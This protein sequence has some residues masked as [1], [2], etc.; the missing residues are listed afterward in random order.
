MVPDAEKD[1]AW[2]LTPR[3][4]AIPLLDTLPLIGQLPTIPPAKFMAA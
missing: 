2:D 4:S 3:V 1:M